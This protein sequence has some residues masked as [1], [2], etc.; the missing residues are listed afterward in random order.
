MSELKQIAPA[1]SQRAL[2]P[3][4]PPSKAEV[5][6]ATRIAQKIL[7][8][9][10]DYGKAPSEYLLSI[11]EV[12]AYQIPEV[13]EA[14]AHPLTGIATRCKYLPTVAD[15]K[16]FIEDRA[17][18]LNTRSTTY[19]YLKPGEGDPVDMP[20]ENRRKAQVLAELGYDPSKPRQVHRPPLD[21]GIVDAI[22][23]H[24]WSSAD[25][26]TPAKPASAELKALILQQGG[27]LPQAAK[28]AA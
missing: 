10:P 18:R 20:T 27:S 6:K 23:Q 4:G 21:R 12:I 26:K 16:Q 17:S 7:S 11:T 24:R 13:Q 22:E 14:L 5:S 1:L 9:Y 28:E 19:R 15:I 2:M 8:G 3:S 25:L